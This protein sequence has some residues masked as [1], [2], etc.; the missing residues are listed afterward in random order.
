MTI[1]L[2]RIS[3]RNFAIFLLRIPDRFQMSQFESKF[4]NLQVRLYYKQSWRLLKKGIGSM[5]FNSI[6][7]P[8]FSRLFV[9]VAFRKSWNQVF[10]ITIPNMIKKLILQTFCVYDFPKKKHFETSTIDDL[11]KEQTNSLHHHISLMEENLRNEFNMIQTISP[12]KTQS[13][14]KNLN[15]S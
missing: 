2:F 7:N 4:R 8:E 3:Y 5:K 10:H 1:L 15:F 12:K 6:E 14:K 9:R 13:K 11:I